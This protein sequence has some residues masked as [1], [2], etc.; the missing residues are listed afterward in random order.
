MHSSDRNEKP[1]LDAVYLSHYGVKGM[2]WGQRRNAKKSRATAAV[3][4]TT[5]ASLLYATGT[6]KPTASFVGGRSVHGAAWVGNKVLQGTITVIGT[7]INIL[8]GGR[9]LGLSTAI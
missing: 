2:R 3:G 8:T 5:V 9:L 1:S 6:L 4:A 7:P